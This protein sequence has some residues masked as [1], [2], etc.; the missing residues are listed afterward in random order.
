MSPLAAPLRAV[1]NPQ[2]PSKLH[3]VQWTI[4]IRTEQVF[5]VYDPGPYGRGEMRLV[6]GDPKKPIKVVDYWVSEE[7]IEWPWKE[8]GVAGMRGKSGARRVVA[9]LGLVGASCGWWR[10]TERADKTVDHWVGSGKTG[11]WNKGV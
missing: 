8:W 9:G 2:M 11:P 1:S 10:A 4:E 5:A 3:F 6:A 7:H